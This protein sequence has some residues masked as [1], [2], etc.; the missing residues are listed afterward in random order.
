MSSVVK[1]AAE[2]A[3]MS[4]WSLVWENPNRSGSG[5]VVVLD[6]TLDQ[7]VLLLF[8]PAESIDVSVS[9]EAYRHTV[10]WYSGRLPTP[11]PFD[12]A[13]IFA[14]VATAPSSGELRIDSYR[15]A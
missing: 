12:G 3:A 7:A 14:K 5:N 11:L 8:V 6:S 1:T 10:K 9:A 4:G 13:A 15:A 2:V